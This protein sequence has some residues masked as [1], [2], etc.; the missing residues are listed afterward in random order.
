MNKKYNAV[1]TLLKEIARDSLRMRH[2]AN[3]QT[4]LA[5]A[6]SGVAAVNADITATKK[7]LARAT[8]ALAGIDPENPDAEDLTVKTQKTID[9]ETKTLET[10]NTINLVNAQ[11]A[12]ADM[13]AEIAKVEAGEVKMC[14][15]SV[16]SL[17]KELIKEVTVDAAVK[18]VAALETTTDNS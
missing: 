12:V 10:L 17:T 15:E 2:I 1:V 18:S 3:L 9:R 13:N 11:K 6:V 14:I 8:Y 7:A 16:N 5:G 4:E